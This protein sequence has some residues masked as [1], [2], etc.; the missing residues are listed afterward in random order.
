MI[1]IFSQ[2][3]LRDLYEKGKTLDKKHRFQPDV[4]NGYAKGIYL[5]Q[6]VSKPEELYKYQALHFE[7]LKGDKSDIYSIRATLKYRIEFEI[8]EDDM[9]NTIVKIFNILELSNH[10]Q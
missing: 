1:V 7:K 2:D 8:I 4:I 10:Y 3:Y 5:M 6:S 9:E